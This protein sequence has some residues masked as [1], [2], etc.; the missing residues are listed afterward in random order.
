MTE[1]DYQQLPDS[2][3]LDMHQ[4]L[5]NIEHEPPDYKA[6]GKSIGI[7]NLDGEAVIEQ[8]KHSLSL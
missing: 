5:E 1:D 7:P 6:I 2:I 3:Y 4:F 8:I